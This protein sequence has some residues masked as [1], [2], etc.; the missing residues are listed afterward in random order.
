MAVPQLP[1]AIRLLTGVDLAATFVFAIEGAESGAA[2]GFDL[3]G[4]LAV[5]FAAALGGGIVRDVLIGEV[6]PAALRLL[7]YPIAAFGGGLLVVAVR[8][9][10]DEVPDGVT[11]V[12]DALGLSLFAVA[13]ATKALDRQIRAAIAPLLGTLTAVGGGVMRDVL[14]GDVPVVLRVDVYASAALAGAV[15]TVVAT[16]VGVARPRA[17]ALGGATCLAIRLA[18]LQFDWDLPRLVRH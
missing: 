2:A 13:G 4:V 3:F 7:S 14:L 17:M 11:D 15:T 18:A 9:V 1:T 6:P 10:V 12:L 5:G 8:G 16:G